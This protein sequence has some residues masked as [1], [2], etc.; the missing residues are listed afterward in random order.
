MCKRCHPDHAKR[1]WRCSK[2]ACLFIDQLELH[3]GIKLQHEHYD[4]TVGKY[5]GEEHAIKEWPLKRVDGYNEKEKLVVEFFGDDVH[6]HPLL[7]EN[8]FDRTD[9]HGGSMQHNYFDTSCKMSKLKD[10]GYRVFYIWQA[11][12]DLKTGKSLLPGVYREFAKHL[13]WE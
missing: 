1:E 2:A 9:R 12:T 13:E 11:D 6:G 4:H 8:N 5:V 3:L 10:L 7:W